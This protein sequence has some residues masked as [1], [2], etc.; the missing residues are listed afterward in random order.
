MAYYVTGFYKEKEESG[1]YI[2]NSDTQQ[3]VKMANR[4]LKNNTD[5]VKEIKNARLIKSVK[6]LDKQIL[7]KKNATS[8]YC[9]ALVENNTLIEDTKTLVYIDFI[10]RTY[11][12]VNYSG[13]EIIWGHTDDL[14]KLTTDH[15]LNNL[16]YNR[17]NGQLNINSY[18]VIGQEKQF[19]IVVEGLWNDENIDET[20]NEQASEKSAEQE[21]TTEL[22][23]DIYVSFDN[24]T[25]VPKNIK[26][27]SLSEQLELYTNS[28]NAGLELLS[29]LTV[30]GKETAA[31]NLRLSQ[32]EIYEALLM[33]LKDDDIITLPKWVMQEF[34]FKLKFNIETSMNLDKRI[35]LG[36]ITLSEHSDKIIIAIVRFDEASENVKLQVVM[37]YSNDGKGDY[38][39]ETVREHFIKWRANKRYVTI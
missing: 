21:I 32:R 4:L 14:C 10:K 29:I 27:E 19:D 26:G 6:G 22:T 15:I 16:T 13:T 3:T 38:S 23:E 24:A 31:K 39:L 12:A 7:G 33:M 8:D 5:I 25:L 37:G 11:G 28:E 18:H 30:R 35:S 9:P 1:Y 17:K 34:K 2:F 20:E 36:T